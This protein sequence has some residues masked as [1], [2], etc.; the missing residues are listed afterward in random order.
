MCGG[1]ITGG[2]GEYEDTMSGPYGDW[3]GRGGS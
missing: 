2:E 3:Y 1:V